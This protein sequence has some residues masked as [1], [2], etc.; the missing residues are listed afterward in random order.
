MVRLIYFYFLFVYYKVHVYW[1][2]YRMHANA[3]YGMMWYHISII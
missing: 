2:K 3:L 1:V